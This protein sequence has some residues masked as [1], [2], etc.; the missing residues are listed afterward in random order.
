MVNNERFVTDELA[1]FDE[2]LRSASEDAL[3]RESEL[4]EQVLADL[5]QFKATFSAC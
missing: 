1:V 2:D 3:I 4:F 5:A